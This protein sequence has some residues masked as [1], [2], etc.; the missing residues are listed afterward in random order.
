MLG[1]NPLRLLL[2]Q[3]TAQPV[4]AGA[5]KLVWATVTSAFPDPVQVQ[6]D[7]E[8]APLD[9]V[10]SMLCQV[11]LGD[12]VMVAMFGRRMVVL[13]VAQPDQSELITWQAGTVS[14]TPVASTPTLAHVT[15]DVPF[16]QVP[17]IVVTPR[18]GQ[19]QQVF[20]SYGSPAVDGF[21]IYLYRPDTTVTSVS[22]TARV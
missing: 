8:D 4:S 10:P 17:A 5:V 7:A 19:P 2:K 3:P 16:N 12:R 22:W 6:V 18:T 15:F 1:P 11:G 14:I 9:G 13:G 20:A 21:D